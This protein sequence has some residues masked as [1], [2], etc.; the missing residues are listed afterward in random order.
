MNKSNITPLS[1]SLLEDFVKSTRGGTYDIEDM[2]E[3]LVT[4]GNSGSILN[5]KNLWIITDPSIIRECERSTDLIM[6]SVKG[7]QNNPFYTTFI[8]FFEGSFASEVGHQKTRKQVIGAF[9][10]KRVKNFSE[11]V[12]SIIHDAFRVPGLAVDAAHLSHIITDITLEKFWSVRS[13]ATRA[14]LFGTG[15]Q[16]L[17]I[18]YQLGAT[19]DVTAAEIQPDIDIASLLDI[20][21]DEISCT[22]VEDEDNTLRSYLSSQVCNERMSLSEAADFFAFIIMSGLDTLEASLTNILYILASSPDRYFSDASPAEIFNEALRMLTPVTSSVRVV[23]SENN[24]LPATL[25][26]M[27]ILHHAAANQNRMYFSDPEGW[28][29]N[30]VDRR[31]ATIFG[32]GIHRCLGANLATNVAISFTEALL[33]I[34]PRLLILG[35]KTPKLVSGSAVQTV[36]NLYISR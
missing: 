6:P 32:G 14:M 24:I 31:D 4:L 25:G 23:E 19:D 15:R 13:P 2:H 5:H 22:T 33:D 16:M 7:A 12:S 21:Q 34:R 3:T 8:E 35:D 9:S 36:T 28:H 27:V 1:Q 30:W 29:P 17:A 10:K 11:H 26:D 18:L 20:L